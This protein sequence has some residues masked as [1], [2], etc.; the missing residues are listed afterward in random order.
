MQSWRR[1]GHQLHLPLHFVPCTFG[2]AMKQKQGLK[3]TKELTLK[4][5]FN[6]KDGI[7]NPAL[8]L[9]E[10]SVAA[11]VPRGTH[12]L[13]SPSDTEDAGKPRFYLLTKGDGESFGFCLRDEV[14]YKG[15]IIRQVACG[16]IAQRRGLQDGDRIL[17]VNG[18]YVDNMEHFRVVQKI[19]AS[20]NQVAVAVL[21]GNA[22]EVA[23]ALNKNLAELLLGHTRP[24]LCHVVKDKSGF[25]FS[26]SAPEGVKG[27]F[28]LS[29]T[30]DGPADKAGVP[31]DSWLLELNGASVRNYTYARL[32]RKLKQSGSKVT[33]LVI[34]AKSEE[35]YRLQGVRVIAAMADAA[36]LPFKAREL[37]MVKGPDGYGFLLKEEKC[38]SGRMGQFLSE[39]DTGLPADRAGMRDRDRL[40]AVNGEGVEGLCHQEVVDMI[41]ASGHQVTLLVIDPDGDEFYSLMGLSPLLFCEDGPHSSGTH[42][43]PGSHP[44]MPQRNGTPIGTPRLC[45]LDMGPEG[46]GFQLQTITDKPGVFITQVAGGSAGKRAGLK[47]GDMVIEVNG[48][49]V[50]Q[51][52]YKEVLGRIKESGQQLT[53]L[54]VEQEV[55]RSYREMGLAITAVVAEGGDAAARA[56][57]LLGSRGHGVRTGRD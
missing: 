16:G 27:T 25:G 55:L 3:D 51:E 38:S 53:L 36:T 10:D 33:L 22:Y 2:T 5:E 40:L 15:H 49:N 41:R 39:I 48:S 50:E 20:G 11:W 32:T 34:D 8:S 21:D 57:A 28:R 47:E 29:V 9:A 45:H 31:S 56:K 23:K 26:V 30:S 46:F 44:S 12:R 54:V 42:T 14:G 35:F 1:R 37:H 19:K 17:E 24:Q 7:D 43:A 13:C 52:S 6:P 4:F 18:E